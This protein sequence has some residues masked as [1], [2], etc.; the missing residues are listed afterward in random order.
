[1]KTSI[2][3]PASN[4]GAW[5]SHCLEAVFASKNLK[6]AQVIVVAN[7]CTDRTADIA[8]KYNRL[9][10]EIGWQLDVIERKE[11]NKL[12]ALNA[13]EGAAIGDVW[14]YLDADVRVSERVLGQIEKALSRPDARWA[15]GKLQMAAAS[16]VSRAYALFWGN[17]PF[18][19]KSVP[20]AGL[21]AVNK[22]GR[23]R[24]S[25]FP[26]IIS[27]D[28]FV[29]LN[30][31]PRERI[32]VPGTYVWPVAEGWKNLINVRRRQNAGVAELEEFYP[33]LMKNEDK[34][35]FSAL[36]KLNLAL[37]HPFGFFV[38]T[39]VSL[40]VRATKSK[41]GSEWRRGR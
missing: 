41:S 22:E 37:K 39:S 9:A 35:T 29:R 32:G 26:D 30:F 3:I 28:M 10:K 24:W 12:K 33:E 38:Y 25:L 15:S 18:M 40:I 17:V 21:F 11:G 20:G 1:M 6:A 8:R 31:E 36:E 34:G 14:I 7:G 27:D 16:R 2:I 4:E 19:K 23:K 13:G 5:I